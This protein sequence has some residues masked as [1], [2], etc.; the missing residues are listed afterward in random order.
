MQDPAAVA[1]PSN[2]LEVTLALALVTTL[3]L[4]IAAIAGSLVRRA[5]LAVEGPYPHGRAQSLL[6][7]TVRLV[8]F[9]VFFTV[10]IVLA[11]PALDF[12]GVDLAVGLHDE[13]VARW[14][15]RAGVRM[16]LL[17]LL[18]F[19]ANRIAG[20]LISRAETEVLEAGGAIEHERR[21]R[22]ATLAASLRRFITALIWTTAVLVVLREFD[23][24]ITPILTG[25][26]ILGLAIGFGAQ[27]LVKD[28]ISGIFLIIEDQVR[29]GD[30]ALVNGVGGT[31]EQI[32]L[33]T[34]VMR[35]VDGSV[36]VIP[37][38]EIRTLANRSKDF[39]WYILD[40]GVDYD[41]DTD[42]AV[43]AVKAAA[44]D[45]QADPMF[46]ASILEPLEVLG[47]DS[48]GASAVG[49]KFR[50]KTLPLMQWEVG[51]E[52]RRRVKKTFDA[53]GIRIPLPQMEV[54]LKK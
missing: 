5:F 36:H 41:V 2:S 37:N 47:V 39:A 21:K 52:L 53:R 32:N 12:V 45:L 30:V 38:G 29:V 49:L 40:L 17:L 7:P 18:T 51:R 35:D 23:I 46:G 10:A 44:A 42:D 28:F 33:R 54:T 11:F 13:D 4:A 15:A 25:A 1:L 22:T 19:G 43:E 50:L 26:G 6:R 34:I 3:A 16:V 24:D 31:V 20:A 14:A 48:F 9:V 8:R 27:T